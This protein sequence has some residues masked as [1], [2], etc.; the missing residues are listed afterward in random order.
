MQIRNDLHSVYLSG[1]ANSIDYRIY[2]LKQLAFLIKDNDAAIKK[3]MREDLGRGD[4]EVEQGEVW[5]LRK[6][7]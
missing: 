3:A 5:Q 1:R 6:R 4:W 2:Q 7:R